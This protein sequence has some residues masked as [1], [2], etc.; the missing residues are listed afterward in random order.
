MLHHRTVL[1]PGSHYACNDNG[2]GA[3]LVHLQAVYS[4][5]SCHQV[6]IMLIPAEARRYAQLLTEAAARAEANDPADDEADE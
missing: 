2:L 1:R 3:V 4:S 6:R 5:G